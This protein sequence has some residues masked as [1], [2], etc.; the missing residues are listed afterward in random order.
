MSSTTLAGYVPEVGDLVWQQMYCPTR[1]AHDSSITERVAGGQTY[2]KRALMQVVAVVPGY[3]STEYARSLGVD[4][5]PKVVTRW[6][7][8]AADPKDRRGEFPYSAVE[9]DWCVL[10]YVPPAEDGRL[11]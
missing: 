3:D 8:Q 9:D 4:V 6:L 11:F 1:P 2:G 10:E 5:P 7:L